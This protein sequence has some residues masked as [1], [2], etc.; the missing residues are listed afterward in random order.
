MQ[1]GFDS[2]K[3][4]FFFFFLIFLGIFRCG[5]GDNFAR[6]GVGDCGKSSEQRRNFFVFSLIF[7]FFF[8]KKKILVLLFVVFFKFVLRKWRTTL[9]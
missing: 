1:N 9:C 7:F 6:F 4:Q 5:I 3:K 2:K 8:F